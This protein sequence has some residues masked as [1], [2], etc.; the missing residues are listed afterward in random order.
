[1]LAF[2]VADD[3]N[4]YGNRWKKWTTRIILP[5]SSLFLSSPLYIFF[6]RIDLDFPFL[7]TYARKYF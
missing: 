7:E 2:K 4:A 3:R 6:T 5:I 1:M